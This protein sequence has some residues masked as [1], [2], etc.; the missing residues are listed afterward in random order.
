MQEVPKKRLNKQQIPKNKVTLISDSHG[1]NLVW[2]LDNQIAN[3]FSCFGHVIPGAEVETIISAAANDKQLKNFKKSDFIVL[4]AGTNNVSSYLSKIGFK[5]Q[6]TL[7][8]YISK[9]EEAVLKYTHTNL[10][11]SNPLQI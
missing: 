3:D 8:D 1:K 6:N 9:I 2:H 7:K 5:K 4:I 10:I 11:L